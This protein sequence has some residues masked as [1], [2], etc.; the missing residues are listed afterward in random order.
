AKQVGFPLKVLHCQEKRSTEFGSEQTVITIVLSSIILTVLLCT[1]LEIYFE[2]FGV[3]S[4][5]KTQ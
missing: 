5:S 1:A 4:S 3:D 2:K